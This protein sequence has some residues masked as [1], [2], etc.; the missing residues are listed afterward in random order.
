MTEIEVVNS[1]NL[2]DATVKPQDALRE[3][4]KIKNEI[5]RFK[6]ISEKQDKQS[7]L[8]GIEVEENEELIDL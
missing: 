5:D 1:D 2:I 8:M 3:L 4:L 7:K 6:L